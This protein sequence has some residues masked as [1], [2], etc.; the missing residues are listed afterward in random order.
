MSDASDIIRTCL[1]ERD[2]TQKELAE[3]LREDPRALNKQLN[4]ADDIKYS[5]MQQLLTPLGYELKLVDNSKN[6]T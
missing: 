6:N 2:M 3:K 1:Q 4:V 5:R